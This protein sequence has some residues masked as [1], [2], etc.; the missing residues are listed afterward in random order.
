MKLKM[1]PESTK[2]TA[3]KI[4]PKTWIKLKNISTK[5]RWSMLKLVE[6]AINE[7]AKNLE[8]EP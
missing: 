7:F 5:T 3:I 2:Y 6:M 8:V 4:D 1:K